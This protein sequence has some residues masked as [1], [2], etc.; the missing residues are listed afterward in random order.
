[1][2]TNLELASAFTALKKE[3]GISDPKLAILSDLSAHG[4]SGYED[5]TARCKINPKT[6]VR[7]TKDLRAA[8][9]II[10]STDVTDIRIAHFSLSKAGKD[11]VRKLSLVL[12]GVSK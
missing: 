7:Y 1:M 8:G 10:R 6:I 3:L 2:S 9:Y 4:K 5:L 11:A 12:G